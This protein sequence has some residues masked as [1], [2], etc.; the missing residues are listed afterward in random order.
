MCTRVVIQVS[1]NSDGVDRPGG[2]DDGEHTTGHAINGYIRTK[3]NAWR[4]LVSS[5]LQTCSYFTAVKG[6][7]CCESTPAG[8]AC[9]WPPTVATISRADGKAG[10]CDTRANAQL[11]PA[12]A[13]QTSAT[14]LLHAT[15]LHIGRRIRDTWRCDTTSCECQETG[16]YDITHR[17]GGCGIV[18][19]YYN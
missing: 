13:D 15:P 8:S 12:Q 5:F 7:G 1:I 3:I 2:G 17:D 19:V 10:S 6:N 16:P 9:A 4:R 14:R 18:D 11:T